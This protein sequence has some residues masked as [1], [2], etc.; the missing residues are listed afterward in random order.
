MALA[1]RAFDEVPGRGRRAL[2]AL[3]VASRA[4]TAESLIR[5]R[6]DMEL[7]RRAAAPAPVARARDAHPDEV[8][9]HPDRT[10]RGSTLPDPETAHRAALSAF[11]AG[12]IILLVDDRQVE[13]LET[14]IGLTE[15][16][17]VTFLQLVPLVGG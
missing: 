1:V 5:Q 16:T 6:V 7:A 17:E 4:V 10:T 13:G 9:L 8:A 12:R 11:A 15:T 3:Q 2:P 14:R